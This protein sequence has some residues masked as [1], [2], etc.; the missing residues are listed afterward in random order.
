MKIEQSLERIIEILEERLP[1]NPIEIELDIPWNWSIQ[2]DKGGMVS[3]SE[4]KDFRPTQEEQDFINSMEALTEA[5]P[6]LTPMKQHTH[7][8][9]PYDED[10]YYVILDDPYQ[11]SGITRLLER[12]HEDRPVINGRWFHGEDALWDEIYEN[13][14]FMFTEDEIMSS[15]PYLWE[16][17]EEA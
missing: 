3:I 10:Y 17:R 9:D 8:I 12:N 14:D 2:N 5:F 11:D 16:L 4:V 1:E 15:H 6:L 7:F 13:P